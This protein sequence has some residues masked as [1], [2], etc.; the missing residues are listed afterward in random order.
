M[1]KVKIGKGDKVHWARKYNG[2]VV[3]LL[4]RSMGDR[5]AYKE[6]Q[7]EVT[8]KTCLRIANK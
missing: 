7:D 5:Y 2:P 4:C 1:I 6:T 8:C 3:A